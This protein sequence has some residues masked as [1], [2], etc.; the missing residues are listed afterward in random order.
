[1]IWCTGFCLLQ[2]GVRLPNDCRFT[3]SKN[4]NNLT[5][6]IWD[7]LGGRRGCSRRCRDWAGLGWALQEVNFRINSGSLSLIATNTGTRFVITSL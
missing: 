1:M 5:T 4:V 3:L 6:I 2:V 7:R